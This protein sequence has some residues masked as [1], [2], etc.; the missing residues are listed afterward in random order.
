MQRVNSKDALLLTC[1][2]VHREQSGGVSCLKL[3]C[4]L[5]IVPRVPVSGN[6]IQ[7]LCPRLCMSTD[8]C[9]VSLRVKH[10]CIIIQVFHFDMDIRLCTKA[11]LIN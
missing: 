7:D 3:V 6:D 1:R 4:D 11:T 5:P 2:V 8:A 10:R 9:D